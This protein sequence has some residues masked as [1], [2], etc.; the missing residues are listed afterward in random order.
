[1]SINQALPAPGLTN[2][3]L[4]LSA[5]L[6]TVLYAGQEVSTEH[7]VKVTVPSL[8]GFYAKGSAAAFALLSEMDANGLNHKGY[9]NHT[10]HWAQTI[11]DKRE[12]HERRKREAIA[13]QERMAALHATPAEIAADVARRKARDAEIVSRFGD[14][15]KRAHFGG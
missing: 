11:V 8:L 9:S 7:F 2:E 5:D 6:Q 3:K 1:M 14:R 13:H 12:D 10:A 15:G 4:T